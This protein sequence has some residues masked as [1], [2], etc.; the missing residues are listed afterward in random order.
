LFNKQVK[1]QGLGKR[2]EL[3]KN[4]D[5]IKFCYLKRPNPLQ[6]NVVSYPLNIPKELGLHKYIDYDMMFTKSFLDPIQVIL[7]AVGWDAEPVASLEDFFG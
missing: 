1:K 3:V 4:G 7:D 6:E 5:K 2:F